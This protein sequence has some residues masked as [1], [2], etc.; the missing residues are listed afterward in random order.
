MIP[1]AQKQYNLL[2][3]LRENLLDDEFSNNR[4]F[5]AIFRGQE[6]GWWTSHITEDA[7][8]EYVATDFCKA[9]VVRAHVIDRIQ[10]M[11]ELL[12]CE[13]LPN[14]EALQEF[15][16]TR[17]RCVIATK[18]ENGTNQF[19][20]LIE[21]PPHLFPTANVGFKYRKGIEGKYLVT[22]AK[23]LGGQS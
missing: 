14:P 7:L 19:S 22:L 12:A 6:T 13:E 21:L 5:T 10:T 2:K 18:R 11:R 20:R 17:N 1:T 9:K 23:T 3:A 15:M 8:K 16:H 4:L